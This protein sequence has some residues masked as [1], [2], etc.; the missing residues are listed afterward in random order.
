MIYRAQYRVDK[1]RYPDRY[2]PQ[3]YGLYVE[4]LDLPDSSPES[5]RKIIYDY[6]WAK[7]GLTEEHYKGCRACD[8]KEDVDSGWCGFK[9]TYEPVLAATEL[10][11]E[12]V[13]EHLE[14]AQ[15]KWDENVEE[16]KQRGLQLI[17]LQKK[18]E[19]ELMAIRNKYKKLKS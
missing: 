9:C 3:K 11:W 7:Y 12:S 17:A 18:E 15:Q 14:A 16:E 6:G 2:M 4:Y 19:E 1:I 13:T 10:T 5:H 8:P